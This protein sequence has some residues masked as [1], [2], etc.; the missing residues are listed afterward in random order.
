[1]MDNFQSLQKIE[2]QI[3]NRHA[4][5]FK[6]DAICRFQAPL[7]TGRRRGAGFG[8]ACPHPVT[9]VCIDTFVYMGGTRKGAMPPPDVRATSYLYE[10]GLSL[11]FKSCRGPRGDLG[12]K[13]TGLST[14]R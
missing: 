11:P 9:S 2:Y 1:M 4:F 8:V 3:Q 13:Q 10:L 5:S 12:V 14:E 7:G 6:S